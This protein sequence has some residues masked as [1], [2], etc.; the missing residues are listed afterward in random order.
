M[1]VPRRVDQAAV[2]VEA[3]QNHNPDVIIV[4]EIGTPKVR[5]SVLDASF[6]F[7]TFCDYLYYTSGQCA[8][9]LLALQRCHA[10][11]VEF[12]DYGLWQPPDAAANMYCRIVHARFSASCTS[13]LVRT[14]VCIVQSLAVHSIPRMPSS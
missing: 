3:V 10:A 11:W 2:L 13:P 4:D 1:M 6:P 14:M 8:L 7:F 9:V 5:C 12:S